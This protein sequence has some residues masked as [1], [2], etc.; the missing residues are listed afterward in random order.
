MFLAPCTLPLLPAYLGFISGVTEREIKDVEIRKRIRVHIFKNSLMFVVGFSTILILS[1]ITA[2]YLGGRIPFHFGRF[3]EILSGLLIITFGLFMMGILKLSFLQ[4][5]RRIQIPKWLTVGTPLSS[6]LLG[7]AFAIGWTPCL[8]PV[9]GTILVYAGNTS[10]I[11]SGAL[12]LTVFSAGFSVPLLILALLIG[13]ATKF[14]EKVTPYL[15]M[16]SI[17]GGFVLL[18]LG[19]TALFGH[20]QLTNWFYYLLSFL[21]FEE[22]LMPYL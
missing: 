19:M 8:G 6:L 22:A 13:Q 14:V 7:I 5:E 11:F 2:G 17:G 1:G 15:H 18:L 16:F 21:D 10:T 4:K 9:Y 20:T 12:L 3:F